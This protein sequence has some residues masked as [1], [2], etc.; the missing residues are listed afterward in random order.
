MRI[1]AFGFAERDGD[2][3]SGG[4]DGAISDAVEA[5]ALRTQNTQVCLSGVQREL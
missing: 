3:V 2:G 4:A 1:E 5:A